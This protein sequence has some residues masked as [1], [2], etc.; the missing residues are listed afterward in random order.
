[1]HA[2]E[3]LFTSRQYHEISLDDII[4]EAGVGKGTVYRYFKG[5]DDLFFQTATSGFEELQSLIATG[6]PGHLPFTEQLAITCRHISGFLTRRRQLSRMMQSEDARMHWLKGELRAA[7]HA[8]RH[9]LVEAIAEILRKGVEEG[10]LRRDVP[11]EALATY[12]FGVLRAR[13]SGCDGPVDEALPVECVVDLFIHGA[14]ESGLVRVIPETG[15][16]R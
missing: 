5:K 15:E 11:P 16:G 3:K 10:Q 14:A 7:W 13:T 4:H 12:L 2:A 9:E 1:M 8:R 6:V